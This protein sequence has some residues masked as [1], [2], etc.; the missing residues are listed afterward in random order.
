MTCLKIKRFITMVI[1]K[2]QLA[3]LTLGGKNV[4][5]LTVAK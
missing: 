3:A 5:A 4:V 2:L 1:W